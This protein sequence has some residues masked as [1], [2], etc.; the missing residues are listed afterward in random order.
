MPG[1]QM[2][3]AQPLCGP[4]IMVDPLSK[5]TM[6]TGDLA[7]LTSDATDEM[8]DRGA[9]G[10]AERRAR[11]DAPLDARGIATRAAFPPP[12]NNARPSAGP[13]QSPPTADNFTQHTQI[14]L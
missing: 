10:A 3:R 6:H 9:I 8:G 4:P 13:G 12:A 14:L 1:L 5:H 11:I 2:E 7:L